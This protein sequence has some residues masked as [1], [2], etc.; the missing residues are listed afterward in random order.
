MS[1]DLGDELVLL[2]TTNREMHTVNATGRVV[3]LHAEDGLDVIIEQLRAQF[4]VD[5]ATATADAQ[6]LL[7]D[8]LAA[9]LLVEKT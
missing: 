3:W 6:E 9:G 7:D 4:D 8:L 1:T 5:S 2:N